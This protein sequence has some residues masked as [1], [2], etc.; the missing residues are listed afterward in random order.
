M[1]QNL[2]HVR[3]IEA[4]NHL[5]I[6]RNLVCKLRERI[7]DGINILISIEMV[8]IDVRDDSR[9]RH[10]R[11]EAAVKFVTFGNEV[12]AVAH[13]GTTAL[14]LHDTAHDNRRVESGFFPNST[15]D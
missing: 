5:T 7:F 4:N 6:K 13:L 14:A 3:V 15:N 11:K 8:G 9:R 10:H 12:I 2:L 1:S